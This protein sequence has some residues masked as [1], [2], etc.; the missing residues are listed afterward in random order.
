MKVL[1]FLLIFQTAAIAQT[2]SLADAARQER[3]RRRNLPDAPVITNQTIRDLTAPPISDLVAKSPDKPEVKPDQKAADKPATGAAPHDEA[4]W[5]DTFR[6]AREDLKRA[7]EHVA[8]AQLELNKLNTEFLTRSDIY[9]REQ[10]LGPKVNAK[11][12]ELAI[13][14]SDVDRAR[15]KLAQLEEDL[16][17]AGGPPGWAR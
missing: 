9:D 5:H 17:R 8:V 14:Q 2:P 12:S 7:E 4:W 10:Q 16:R 13:A 3:E 6:T 15:E 1:W 11:R